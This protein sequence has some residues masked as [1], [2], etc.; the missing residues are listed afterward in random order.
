MAEEALRPGTASAVPLRAEWRERTRQLLPA[1]AASAAEI[2][3]ERRLP[4][5]LVARLK[6]AGFFG[7][8]VPGTFGGAELDPPAFVEILEAIA[9]IDASTAW[10][11]G[12]TNV[13]NS[14]AA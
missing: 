1:I 9:A 2:E 5:S 13:C 8:L 4:E 12:Q 3:R 7:L 10:C 11:L 6:A 14:V